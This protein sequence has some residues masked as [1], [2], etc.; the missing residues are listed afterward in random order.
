M[1]FTFLPKSAY[2]TKTFVRYSIRSKEVSETPAI[3][4]NGFYYLGKNPANIEK[5]VKLFKR[6]YASDSIS[7]ARAELITGYRTRKKYFTGDY[8]L[9]IQFRILSYKKFCSIS[10]KQSPLFHDS[11]YHGFYQSE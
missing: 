7:N 5:L 10:K 6:G 4:H 11:I 9:R 1:D 8:I 2:K 3:I